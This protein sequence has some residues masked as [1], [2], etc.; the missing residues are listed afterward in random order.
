[1]EC[2]SDGT[3]WDEIGTF[4]QTYVDLFKWKELPLETPVAASRLRITAH[5]DKGWMELGEVAV[6]DANG[7]LAITDG[8]LA[9]SDEQS[10]V[11]AKSTWFNST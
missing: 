7:A 8:A 5:P 6:Y 4:D 9:L 2:S 10:T 3:V 1:M 11:P